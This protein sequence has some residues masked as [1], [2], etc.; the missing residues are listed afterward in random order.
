MRLFTG[1]TP[2]ASP[3]R[4]PPRGGHRTRGFRL[5]GV[6]TVGLAITALVVTGAV[7]NVQRPT[8]PPVAAQPQTASLTAWSTTPRPVGGGLSFGAWNGHRILLPAAVTPPRGARLSTILVGRGV[9]V[10]TCTNGR[11]ALTEPLINLFTTAGRPTGLHFVVPNPVAPLIWGSSVDGSRADMMIV[12]EVPNA[13]TVTS[14]LLR[15]VIVAGGPRTTFGRTAFIVRLPIAGG[16]PPA[17]C[18]VQ[19]LRIGVPFLTLYLIFRGGTTSGGLAVAAPAGQ[20]AAAPVAQPAAVPAAQPAAVP[21]A[22]G[23]AATPYVP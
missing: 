10:Y 7:A 15:A 21:A 9:L 17:I 22:M 20:P 11:F 16:L 3:E 8:D 14:V 4:R 19:G 13:N 1:P 2:G 23:P 12:V 18:A 6:V 5:S